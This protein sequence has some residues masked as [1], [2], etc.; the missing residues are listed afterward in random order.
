MICC[1]EPI[2]VVPCAMSFCLNLS[3][4]TLMPKACQCS[5]QKT[6]G[7]FIKYKYYGCLQLQFQKIVKSNTRQTEYTC[8]DYNCYFIYTEK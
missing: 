1:L 4:I 8:N 6:N 2:G 3:Q 5:P 7:M